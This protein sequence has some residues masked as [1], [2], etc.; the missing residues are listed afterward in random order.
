M[1]NWKN[2]KDDLCI[3]CN[4]SLGSSSYYICKNC[5]KI[6]LVF[7]QKISDDIIDVKSICCKA[8]ITLHSKITCSDNCHKKFVQKMIR[9]NGRYKK[10]TDLESNTTHRIPTRVIIEKGIL[11]NDIK[12][13]P[14]W[15][16]FASL[17]NCFKFFQ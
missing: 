17:V 16:W 7:S 6:C 9:E 4:T 2:V 12:K 8:D 15:N 14:Q 11:Q 13:Y 5:S 1:T 3:V 10:V